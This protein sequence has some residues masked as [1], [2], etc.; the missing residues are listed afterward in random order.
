[1]DYADC[2]GFRTEDEIEYVESEDEMQEG[3][4]ATSKDDWDELGLELERELGKGK[5]KEV[6][7]QESRRGEQEGAFKSLVKSYKAEQAKRK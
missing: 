2:G 3:D 4:S 7:G 6:K 1:M 5:G